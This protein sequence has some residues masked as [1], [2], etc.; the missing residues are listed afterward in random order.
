M[1]EVRA[2]TA[3]LR[4]GEYD[5][6]KSFAYLTGQ[7]MG[8]VLGAAVRDFLT[9]DGRAETLEQLQDRARADFRVL[10]E[11]LGDDE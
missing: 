10:L 1:S 11:A 9:A 8:E 4:K 5:A 6:I 7:T 2:F 3:R